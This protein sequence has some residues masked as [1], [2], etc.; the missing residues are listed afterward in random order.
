[1]Q[2]IISWWTSEGAEVLGAFWIQ[3]IAIIHQPQSGRR[4][5]R[6]RS[7]RVAEGSFDVFR[8]WKVLPEPT[9]RTAFVASFCDSLRAAKGRRTPPPDPDSGRPGS[10]TALPAATVLRA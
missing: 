10:R 6:E 4:R 2:K 3:E 9:L 5:C 7:T 8:V 1:M